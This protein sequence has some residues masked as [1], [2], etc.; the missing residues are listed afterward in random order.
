MVPNDQINPIFLATVSGTDSALAQAQNVI[1]D[2]ARHPDEQKA[3]CGQNKTFRIKLWR[4]CELF[5]R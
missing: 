1:D 3:N 4:A 2:F 5:S